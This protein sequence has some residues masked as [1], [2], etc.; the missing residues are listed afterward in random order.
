M[1][2]SSGSTTTYFVGSHHEVANGVVTKYYYAGSQR[3]AMRTNGTLSY[4]L[5][6]HLGSTS[7]VTD[8]AGA[9]VSETRYK[10]WGETRYTSGTTPTKYQYTGQYSYTGD[11]GLM[12]YQ[13][14]WYD[15][16][17]GRFAQADSIIPQG[18]GVQA[19][20]RFAY[21]NNSPVVYSDPSGHCAICY[22]IAILGGIGIGVITSHLLGLVPDY[23][24]I[25]FAEQYVTDKNAIVGA[26]IAVQSEYYGPWDTRE[27]APNGENSGLGIAQIKDSEMASLDLAG[28]DQEDPTIAVQAMA[29]RINNA[30][31][32]CKRCN[33]D[34]DRF[35]VA[36]L[37]QNGSGFGIDSV[38]SLPLANDQINWDYVMLNN[39]RNSSDPIANLRQSA[40]RMSYGTQFMLRLFAMDVRTLMSKGFV[41]PDGY[42]NVNWNEIDRLINL[43]QPRRYPLYHSPQ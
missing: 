9:V 36:A 30:V 1:N 10:A 21:A 33:N 11:F 32:A 12:F 40:T 14:R 17:L 8:A 37:S 24:G 6:D 2:T 39:G 7:L 4:L 20:D 42:R 13:A 38:K 3:V 26:G 22:G 18:Q 34:T 5:G 16:A 28:K 19:W 41:L 25:G 31:S 35:I 23:R 29:T 15:P 27:G 43:R